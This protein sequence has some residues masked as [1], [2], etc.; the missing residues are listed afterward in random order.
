LF[1]VAKF[2][3]LFIFLNFFFGTGVWI[4]D[5]SLLRRHSEY[6]SH[7]ASPFFVVGFFKVGSWELFAWGW[8]WTWSSWSLLPEQLGLQA[9]VCNFIIKF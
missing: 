8:L 9:W 7:S 1:F 2:I 6:L 3:Q 5:L 4:Q